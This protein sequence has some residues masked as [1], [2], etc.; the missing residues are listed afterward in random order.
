[1]SR[2]NIDTVER[3]IGVASVEAYQ[4]K[5]VVHRMSVALQQSPRELG[6]VV[7]TPELL[8]EH[9]TP[10]T[11]PMVAEINYGRWCGTCLCESGVALTPGWPWAGCMD[12]GAT[13][14]RFVFP[15]AAELDAILAVLQL[16]PM[17]P[18]GPNRLRYY[19]WQPGV[20]VADLQQENGRSGWP[21]PWNGR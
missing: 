8:S 21:E 12:C 19:S 14:S 9:S 17:G 1:M 16:R 20:S 7:L 11:D 6:P 13:Y 4:L 5:F 18:G 10:A 15:P 2:P 3:T